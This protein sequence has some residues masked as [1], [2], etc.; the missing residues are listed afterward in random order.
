MSTK[1]KANLVP[2]K[3]KQIKNNILK[4][5]LQGIRYCII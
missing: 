2:A 4:N 5:D 1:P 3:T